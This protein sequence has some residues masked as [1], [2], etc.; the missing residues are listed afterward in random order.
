MKKN[1]ENKSI[2]IYQ[3]SIAK[4]EPNVPGARDIKPIPNSVAKYLDKFF[5]N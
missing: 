4:I 1:T 5:I 3:I 2:K